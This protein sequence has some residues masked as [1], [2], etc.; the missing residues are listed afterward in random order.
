MQYTGPS[1]SL[2]LAK[3][4][5]GRGGLDS[6][7]PPARRPHRGQGCVGARAR[8]RRKEEADTTVAPC[9]RAEWHLQ[10]SVTLA[11]QGCVKQE[12]RDTTLLGRGC[13]A[14]CQPNITPS[15]SSGTPERLALKLGRNSGAL[16]EVG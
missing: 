12:E 11:E 6:C 3:W 9:G 8:L 14:R 1:C 13:Q 7:W 5:L 16:L 10:S 2:V 4:S 15:P